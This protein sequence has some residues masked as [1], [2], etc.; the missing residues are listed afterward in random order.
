[1]TTLTITDDDVT[2][3]ARL[4]QITVT[5]GGVSPVVI[6]KSG[7]PSPRA[8][9]N[10]LIGAMHFTMSHLKTIVGL[11]IVAFMASTALSIAIFASTS[12]SISAWTMGA[13]FG[14]SV[15]LIAKSFI[16]MRG[17]A[18]DREYALNGAYMIHMLGMVTVALVVGLTGYTWYTDV[19]IRKVAV[20]WMS[21]AFFFTTAYGWCVEV[22]LAVIMYQRMSGDRCAPN[23]RLHPL[24][25]SVV[26]SQYVMSVAD[27]VE[28][29]YEA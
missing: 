9:R 19:F 6:S 5:R 16:Y 21:H 25:R 13:M 7:T 4:P 2:A 17:P 11:E 29:P 14:S 27:K 20:S 10:K 8:S 23:C 3:G 12:T 15:A 24:M 26:I 1:M 22:A 28:E 18:G